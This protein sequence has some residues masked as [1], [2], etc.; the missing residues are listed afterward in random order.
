VYA[1][2]EAGFKHTP[3][4]F[5]KDPLDWKSKQMDLS[6][7]IKRMHDLSQADIQSAG[8][9]KITAL[10]NDVGEVAYRLGDII[11]IGL[12]TLKGQPCEV[13]VNL[14]SDNY[15]NMV[16]NS[17]IKVQEGLIELDYDPIVIQGKAK[18]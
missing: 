14:P 8:S 16:D 9:Y 17:L 10:D 7:L 4:L 2:Q 3:S 1:A 18:I 13:P 6:A 15:T 5:D 12:F 11:R